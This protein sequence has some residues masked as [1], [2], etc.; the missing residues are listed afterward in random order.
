MSHFR[1][2]GQ[3]TA[4]AALL[5]ALHVQ[6]ATP[7]YWVQ[8]L[9]AINRLLV[10]G[11]DTFV[12]DINNRGQ[13]TGGSDFG[14][15]SAGQAS[16]FL[17]SDGVVQR[18]PDASST[19]GGAALAINERGD[20]VGL[21][22]GEFD[23]RPMLWRDGKMLDLAGPRD[24]GGV[25]NDINE[26]R[27][28]T[29]RIENRAFIYE[30]NSF[31]F[32]DLPM[33]SPEALSVGKAL[34]DHG[35]IVGDLWSGSHGPVTA[36]RY[37]AGE[38]ALLSS[39]GFTDTFATDINNAGLIAGYGNKPGGSEQRAFLYGDG[40]MTEL[41]SFG[42]GFS[43]LSDLNDAGLAVGWASTADGTELGFV[44]QDGQ[45]HKLNDLLA[46]GAA[47]RWNVAI[48]NAITDQGQIL[49]SGLNARGERTFM[50]LTPV[51]EPST[52]LLMGAGL[53]LL[54]AVARRRAADAAAERA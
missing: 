29:G 35:V 17:Y 24:G 3:A 51:P 1:L 20:V 34:N 26:L 38:L 11:G 12:T 15:I 19:L 25:A 21:A 4:L 46:P 45:M 8:P 30:G 23:R 28:I 44:Y 6:A 54:G 39:P 14:N 42:G 22:R 49:A 40:V 18:L 7:T 5:A 16:P 53:G 50:L 52:W 47:G 36:F 48:G 10:P 41:D 13:V 31:R 9:E 33:P 27:H 43:V 37:E 32:L 2:L